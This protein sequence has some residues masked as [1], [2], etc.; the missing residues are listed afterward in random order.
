MVALFTLLSCGDTDKNDPSLAGTGSGTNYI[1]VVKDV[2]NLKPL[3]KNFDDIRKLLPAAPTG[4]TYTETKLDAAFQAINADETKFLK[5]LNAR[6]SME[7]AKENKNANP[8]EIEKEFLQ[9]LKDLGFAEGDENKD[10]SYAKVR[11]TFM[12]ALVQ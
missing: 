4:K 10:G 7:T 12:D 11:K 5:A 9:V 6:K 3:T 8:A 1:K 2:A